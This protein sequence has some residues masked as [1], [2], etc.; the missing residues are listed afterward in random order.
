MAPPSPPPRA[1][2]LDRDGVLNVKREDY[3]KSI[4]ELRAMPDAGRYLALLQKK[5]YLLIIVT[6]QSAVNRGIISK[7]E[8]DLINAALVKELERSG[9]SINAVYVCPHKP[10]ESCGCRKPMPGLLL[11]AA[12][13]LGVDM[14]NSWIIGDSDT[15]LEA[16]A[17][18]GCKGGIK[19]GTS[20][21]LGRAVGIIL[22]EAN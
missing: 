14:P 7:D 20:T 22:Q 6:N 8:L 11:Q 3:V 17:R 10:D 4:G 2:F 5:G 16:G 15:D 13:E 9:C 12:R 18:A 1:V 21:D 19:L